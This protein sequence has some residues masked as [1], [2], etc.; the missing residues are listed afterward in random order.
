MHG[1]NPSDIANPSGEL[2]ILVNSLNP[3]SSPDPDVNR[4]LNFFNVDGNLLASQWS[5]LTPAPPLA[6][7]EEL[8]DAAS[9]HGQQIIAWD[10]QS[11]QLP[12][13]QPLG[14][15]IANAGYNNVSGY[16]ENIFAFSESVFYGHAG[17]AILLRSR[18]ANDW[19][20]SLT[21]IQN[22]PIDAFRTHGENPEG[23]AP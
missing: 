13:E 10:R 1:K 19:D 22:P 8:H 16:A 4:V 15:R 6:W 9:G 17:L 23:I 3:I 5:S 12:G 11:H 7:S 21:G 18:C 20:D 2:G 14:Q